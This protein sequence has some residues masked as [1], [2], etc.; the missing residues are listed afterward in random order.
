MTTLPFLQNFSWAC[1]RMDPVNASA[2]FAIRSFS[3]SWDI[4][5]CSFGVRLQ[6]PN[7][8]EGEAVG[9]RG[10]YLRKN[11]CFFPIGSPYRL[12]SIFTCFR[13]IAAFVLQH[14][15]FSHPTSSLPKFP[16]VPLGI[17]GWLLGYKKRRCLANCPC[18]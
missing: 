13:D 4:S 3:R 14:A 10:R 5:D 17:G 1:V 18:N 12:S 15:T 6:T 16:Y 2:K 8:G 9:S 11:V 7:L